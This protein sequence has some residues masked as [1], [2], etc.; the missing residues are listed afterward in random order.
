[1]NNGATKSVRSVSIIRHGINGS[2]KKV[3]DQVS[4]EEPLEIRIKGKSIA[5]TMRTPGNDE[6]LALGFL[7]SEGVIESPNDIIEIAH[8]PRNDG[9]SA[10]NIINV[11]L[12]D[13]VTMDWDALTRHVFVSSSCGICGKASIEAVL[14]ETKSIES[15]SELP[16]SLIH[17]IPEKL[18]KAQNDFSKTGG[19]HAAAL[20]DASGDVLCCREDIGRHNA[21]DKVIGWKLRHAEATPALLA[22]SG[23]ASFEIVQKTAIAGIPYLSAVSAPSSL[24]IDL[25]RSS[26]VRLI[27][28]NR[29]TG[30]NHY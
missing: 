21:V 26:G 15:T 1:M 18:F 12:A 13:S 5:I 3:D 25:A 20:F 4:V 24:A 19:L 28:F 14:Q 7:L 10:N 22:V 29:E 11:F 23:R 30:F 2:S 27:G 9:E 17:S 6:E 8:C 16:N